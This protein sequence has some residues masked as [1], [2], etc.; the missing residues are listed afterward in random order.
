[1]AGHSKWAQIKRKK[2]ANDLKKGKVVSKYMRLIAAAAR[3]GG[4]A[5]PAANASLRNLIEAAKYEDVPS[6]NIERLLKRLAG[7]DEEGSHYEEV[8]YEGYAPG[9]VAIIVNAV[10]DNRQRTV[11]EV[12]HV[13]N[14]HGGSLGATGAVAWQFDRRGYIRLETNSD[15]A[16]EAAIEAGALDL[17][18]S[19]G[20]LEIYTDPHEVYTV[21]EALKAKG[22][23]PEDVSI[24]MIPQNVVSLGVEDAEKVLRMVEA[25]EELDDV[26]DVHT[27]LDPASLPVE[28]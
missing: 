27:N 13:F 3:A 15:A 4:S 20:G 2:A 11:A 7:G 21:S 5:D 22:F 18:E 10:T 19:E 28:A 9:G 6:D 17:Q 8:V 14:K 24:T 23:K 1:M 16:Q 12:R 26:Q 25:L